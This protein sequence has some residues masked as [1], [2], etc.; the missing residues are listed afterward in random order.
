MKKR[1]NIILILLITYSW[2]NLFSIENKTERP[3][4]VVLVADDWGFS[5]VGSFGGEIST[6]HLDELAKKGVRFSNFHVT[7]SCSPTRSMLMTGVDNHRNG[8]G[9]MRE[10]IPR[11]HVGKNGYLSVLNQNVVTVAS[12]LKDSGYRTYVAGKWHVGHE[13]HN[14]PP[15]RGFD[16]SLIQADSGS[17]NWETAKKY[18]DLTK[19]VNWYEDGKEAVMPPEYYSSQFYIDKTIEY[20]QS[21]E[22]KGK[23]FFSYIGFQAN[24]LPVQAPREFIDRNLGRYTEGWTELRKKRRDRAVELGIIPDTTQLNT[25]SSTPNWS[26]IKEDDKKLLIRNMEVYAGM[27]EAMDYHVGRLITHLKKTGQYDNTIFIFLSDNGSESSDPYAV[28]TGKIWLWFNYSRDIDRLGEKGTYGVIGPGWATAAA[29]PLNMYKFYSGEGGVR[30]PLII[31]GAKFLQ[32]QI[33]HS[34]AFVKDIV[35][36]ILDIA[37]VSHPGTSYNG[38]PIEPLTGKS[39]LPALLGKSDKIHDPNEPIGYELSGNQALYKGDLKLIKNIPPIGDGEWHLY[40]IKTDPG[41]TK[42]LQKEMPEVFSAMVADYEDYARE[43]GVLPMPKG[44]EPIKQ[45]IINS[46]INVYIPRFRL[47]II[48]LVSLSIIIFIY[49]FRNK[50]RK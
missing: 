38:K 25:M 22:G 12:L 41:E 40:D 6:P 36:T 9:N 26:D 11:E 32:N 24:H 20:I 23:P 47:T 14:L 29:S 3:N 49:K 34:F 45:V 7:A 4:I 28:L 48:I 21:E 13:V 15:N 46:I 16:R 18:L 2:N 33:H 44:Y 19:K 35:P 27:A 5:D 37:N 8:V 42:D 1:I 43:N 50:G 39:M 10:T 30:V 17:D 31:S